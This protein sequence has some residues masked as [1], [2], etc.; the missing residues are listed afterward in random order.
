MAATDKEKAAFEGWAILEL[1][2]HR[3]LGGYV[4]ETT[5]AGAGFVRI[6]VPADPKGQG[7]ATQLYGAAAIYCVTPTTEAIARAAASLSRPEPVQRWE[8]PQPAPKEED[9]EEAELEDDEEWMVACPS[10]HRDGPGDPDA[11]AYR[12]AKCGH[13]W[14]NEEEPAA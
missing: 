6:D 9:V 2:G 12:C 7:G 10:C 13:E 3:R 4:S 11:T 8:L 14:N 5:L 1:M